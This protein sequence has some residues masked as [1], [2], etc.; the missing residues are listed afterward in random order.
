MADALGAAASI[1]TL[2]DTAFKLIKEI[3]KALQS[4][5]GSPK[6]LSSISTQLTSL[7]QSL[8][9]VK[10]ERQLQTAPV[11]Q[12]IEAIIVIENELKLFFGQL[13]ADQKRGPMH[14][15]FRALES[16]DYNDKELASLLGRLNDARQ[17]LILRVTVTHV[18]LTGNV[19]DGF[20]VA[21]DVLTDINAK[22]NQVL[23]MN[24]VLAEMVQNRQ[25]T[26]QGTVVLEDADLQALGLLP[27][28]ST[29]SQTQPQSSDAPSH[30]LDWQRNKTMSDAAIWVG[31]IGFENADEKSTPKASV[32]DN[33]FGQGLRFGV[34]HVGPQGTDAF[35]NTFWRKT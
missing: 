20:R 4:V 12:Q 3:R 10:K 6:T 1:L 30:N 27:S 15:F 22:V 35:V 8:E 33:E 21:Y 34:G 7:S 14:S 9:L 17:D 32:K 2:L 25:R 19:N 29:N 13:E 11:A 18:G 16:G 24:L 28:A 26:S 23:G 31:N 5:R